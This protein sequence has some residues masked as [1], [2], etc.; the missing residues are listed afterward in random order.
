[1]AAAYAKER[2]QFGRPIAMYQAVK[3]HCANML[4]ATELA[5]SAVWDAARAAATGGDQLSYAAAVAATL[6]AP[7]ADLCANLNIQVHGGIAHHVGARRPPVHAAGHHAARTTSTPTRRRRGT[8][9][10]D[11]SGR[12]PREGRSTCRPRPRRSA[13]RSGRSRESIKDLPAER[14]AHP[15]HRDRLRHAALA[16][17]VRACR[18]RGRAARDRAGVRARPASSA[19]PTASPAW[20]ILT[21]IQYATAGPDRPLGAPGAR[22]RT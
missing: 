1:M 21:L 18:R 7:A 15:T 22:T 5:T 10:P 20:D 6:A 9:R 17:A 13:T 16:Q 11:P 12:R 4:V 19:R 3:H 14:A 2:I 8:H